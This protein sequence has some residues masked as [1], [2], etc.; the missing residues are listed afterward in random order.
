MLATLCYPESQIIPIREHIGLLG[1]RRVVNPVFSKP[2][3][4][5]QGLAI[6]EQLY[7]LAQKTSDLIVNL[8]IVDGEE[9]EEFGEQ[10]Y[11]HIWEVRPLGSLSG[12]VFDI[13]CPATLTAKVFR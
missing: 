5:V 12:F 3:I 2:L 8:S 4:E 7:S 9:T 6:N 10:P 13:Y 1:A 11:F